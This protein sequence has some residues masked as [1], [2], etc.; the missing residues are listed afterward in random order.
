MSAKTFFADV[1][2]HWNTPDTSKG[3]YVPYKEYLQIFGGVAFNYGAQSP[4]EYIKFA[5]TCFLIMYHYRLPYL[6]FSVITLIG[7]PMSYLWN[8][9]TWVV[10]DNLGFLGKKRETRFS[11]IYGA[12]MLI[13]L[14]F[15]LVDL[16]ALFPQNSAMIVWMNS[17]SGITATSFFKI[18]GIQILC[19]GYK[20]LRGIFWRKKLIP[21]FGRFKYTLYSDVVQKCILII[22]LGWL[23]I[24]NINSTD[25]RLWM[26]YLLFSLYG[27]FDFSRKI[28]SCCDLISPNSAER[29][30]IRAYPVK[31][32]HFV[33]NIFDALIP[34]LATTAGMGGFEDI[35]FYKYVMPAIFIPTAMVTLLL[36]NKITERIPQPPIEKHQEIPFWYG[37]KEVLHNKYMWINTLTSLIDSMGNGMLDIMMFI[38]LY[39][40][41][42]SGLEYSLIATLYSFRGTIPTFFAPYFIK[43]FPYKK[44][45]IFQICANGTQRALWIV[46]LL[47][48]GHNLK[49]CG[50]LMF[51][52]VFICAFIA[53]PADV[54]SSDMTI[55][56]GDYQ[57]YRSGERLTSFQE[58]FKWFTGPITTLVGLIIPLILLRG[59]F[60]NQYDI[61][62]LDSARNGIL[63]V[64]LAIDLIG[65]IFMTI[66]PLFWNYNI[67]QHEYVIKVLKQ[68][69]RLAEAGYFP[70]EYEGGLNFAEPGETRDG[71]PVNAKE[72]LEK[73]E[74][75]EKAA[76]TA[77]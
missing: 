34:V 52:A 22:L 63:I 41:R 14:L 71:I 29:I 57:M 35:R 13:G 46:C 51:A 30:W 69:E 3:K 43:R 39:T 72:I 70:S 31:L 4:L 65:Y 16:S 9:L 54:A 27:C 53:T 36:A 77:E 42:L 26:A 15:V 11:I 73:L 75:K 49:L 59:G 44:L 48:F 61:L 58:V 56:I 47:L 12:S 33:K 38:Y 76:A 45:K 19:E 68:R 64:P 5:A 18:F 24:Y 37:V 17:L 28:E 66:P 40:L 6:A 60:N 32:S 25:T 21:K 74:E 7:L 2:E 8:I 67:E 10:N 20:G 1:K 62:F 50:W 55:R 23:P